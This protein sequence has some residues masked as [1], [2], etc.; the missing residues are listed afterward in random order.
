M[1]PEIGTV[2]YNPEYQGIR[3]QITKSNIPNRVAFDIFMLASTQRWE[4][5]TN[6]SADAGFWAR[7]VQ[8]RRSRSLV[9]V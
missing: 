4:Y 8:S 1:E 3:V 7:Q 5:K 9:T 6:S 2:W